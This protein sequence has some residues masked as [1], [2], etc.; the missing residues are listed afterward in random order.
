MAT[1]ATGANP[2]MIF[3]Y[4]AQQNSQPALT[5]TDEMGV[6]MKVPLPPIKLNDGI[7]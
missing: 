5:L 4:P 1:G 7:I 6:G 2:I 3:Q